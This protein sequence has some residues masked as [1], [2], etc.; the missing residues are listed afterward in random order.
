[1]LENFIDFNL[2][3]KSTTCILEAAENE[4]KGYLNRTKLIRQDRN[5]SCPAGEFCCN[6]HRFR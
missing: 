1:M 3:I 5:S 6:Y 4:M 2:N